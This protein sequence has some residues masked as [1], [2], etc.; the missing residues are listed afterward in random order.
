M[1][2]Y[3][4]LPQDVRRAAKKLAK[5]LLRTVPAAQKPNEAS[6]RGA[7]TTAFMKPEKLSVLS[8]TL[9]ATVIGGEMSYLT[10]AKNIYKWAPRRKLH[11]DHMMMLL[12]M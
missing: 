8:S 10:R 1:L 2:K 6:I 4:S 7:L 12:N 11:C 5:Q 3:G 9:M